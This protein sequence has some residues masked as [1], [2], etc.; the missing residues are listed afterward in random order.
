[1]RSA[2]R[3]A[4]FGFG[5][6]AIL[7][8]ALASPAQA[9]R[10]ASDAALEQRVVGLEKRLQRLE[11]VEAIEKMTR[12]YGYY[13]DKQ[14]W[15]EVIPLFSD[16][17]VVEISNRGVYRGRKGVAT[18]FHDVIGGGH[19]GLRPGFLSNHMVL[20][21]IVDVDPDGKHAK[22]RWRAF[23]QIGVYQKAALWAEGTYE[24]TYVRDHGVWKFQT[25]H[26]YG[27]YF[28]PF[29]QGWAKAALGNNAPSTTF[30]PDAPPSVTYDSYPGHY[31]PPFHYPNPVTGRA[32]TAED[33][34]QYSTHDM[35][36]AT[37][38]NAP[39]APLAV[40]QSH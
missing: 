15:P 13:I 11:D 3:G 6:L 21:G 14:L 30:P 4:V 2:V 7:A 31:V 35:A 37:A 12:A 29:D 33:S 40:P 1:M 23:I 25:M 5:S 22:G 34:A 36:P 27:T 20:Q 38:A 17:A 8:V 18:L 19:D 24:N 9:A 10:P 16:D 32:W 28:T 39:Q 26:W